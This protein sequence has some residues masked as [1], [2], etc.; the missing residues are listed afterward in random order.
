MDP[1]ARH[2]SFAP[3]SKIT[4]SGWTPR[5]AECSRRPITAPLLPQS[6]RAASELRINPFSIDLH[7]E[8]AHGDSALD[9]LD[10]ESNVGS[11]DDGRLLKRQKLLRVH[12]S[13][14]HP[15]CSEK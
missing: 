10:P 2:F 11:R 4:F 14:A 3:T 7:H 6:H 13:C 15:Q 1:N 9:A 8:L 12:H 5:N